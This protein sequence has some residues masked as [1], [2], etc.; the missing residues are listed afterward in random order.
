MFEITAGSCYN[1][2]LA[3]FLLRTVLTLPSPYF[4][5]SGVFPHLFLLSIQA[6]TATHH[7]FCF[8]ARDPVC[9]P[10]FVS[11]PSHTLHCVCPKTAETVES[12]ALWQRET[13]AY[14]VTLGQKKPQPNQIKA[15]ITA[16]TKLCHIWLEYLLPGGSDSGMRT[17][18][19][20]PSNISCEKWKY[21]LQIKHAE[22]CNDYLD[23]NLSF[24]K[25]RWLF[26][27]SLLFFT[28]YLYIMR[29]NR[30]RQARWDSNSHIY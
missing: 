4:L 26:N 10:R 18:S 12:F 24:H 5:H 16:A 11:T 22:L 3:L 21:D 29:V 23:R 9:A 7:P 13:L 2:P 1:L 6:K 17:R 8:H 20:F 28:E 15:H 25:P 30:N 19:L 14:H 27:L